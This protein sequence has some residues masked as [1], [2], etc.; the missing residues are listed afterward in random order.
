MTPISESVILK[1]VKTAQ[2]IALVSTAFIV[3]TS[4]SAR[5]SEIVVNVWD[6]PTRSINEITSW[7]TKSSPTPAPVNSQVLGSSD[8]TTVPVV[9]VSQSS[10][11]LDNKLDS[12]AEVLEKLNADYQL[13]LSQTILMGLNWETLT[14]SDVTAS[15]DKQN[16]TL[17]DTIQS[18]DW[19]EKAWGWSQTDTIKAEINSIKSN[20]ALVRSITTDSGMQP[21]AYAQVKAAAKDLETVA[22]QVGDK[23]DKSE[24]SQLTLYSKFNHIKDSVAELDAI[25]TDINTISESEATIN[26]TDLRK[27]DAR[28]AALNSIPHFASYLSHEPVNHLRGLE[29]IVNANKNLLANDKGQPVIETWPETTSDKTVAF[30][31]LVVNPS[32]LVRQ[33][34]GIKYYLPGEIKADDILKVDTNLQTKQDASLK[35]YFIEGS[36]VVAAGDSKLLTTVTKDVWIYD[37]AAVD[38]LALQSSSLVDSLAG[39]PVFAQAVALKSKIT[40]DQTRVN[41]LASQMY[42]LEQRLANYRQISILQGNMQTNFDQLQLLAQSAN[43]QPQPELGTWQELALIVGGGVC[44]LMGFGMFVGMG[45]DAE[46]VR[47]TKAKPHKINVFSGGVATSDL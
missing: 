15:I 23:T 42:T 25:L 36:E 43:S 5:P 19:L 3:P 34:I 10:S 45:L 38:A 37:P 2:I 4:V 13:V 29:A 26:S 9:E 16:S 20:L 21:A 8:L 24:S 35:Q 39:L 14:V 33:E 30:K 7:F 41:A 17:T 6:Y 46:S 47:K 31:T 11:D 27:L 44:L 18:L 12:S 40:A 32:V 28:V 22:A 1:F